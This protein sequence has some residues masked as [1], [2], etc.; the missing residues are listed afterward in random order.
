LK[1]LQRPTFFKGILF[2]AWNVILVMRSLCYFE[3]AEMDENPIM[4]KKASWKAIKKKIQDEVV[5]YGS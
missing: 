5:K 3:D 4:L 1:W 2:E